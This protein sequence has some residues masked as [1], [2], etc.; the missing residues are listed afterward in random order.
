MKLRDKIIVG[1][2]IL[3]LILV[4]RYLFQAKEGFFDIISDYTALK[5]RIISELDP[6]FKMS[7]FIREQ[8]KSM[9]SAA[10]GEAGEDSLNERYKAMYSCS[11][12]LASS[13]QTCSMLIGGLGPNTRMKYVSADIYTNL[14]CWSDERTIALALMKIK[15]DLPERIVREYEWLV[16][17]IEKLQ[18]TLS[19]G[20]NPP[21][22]PPSQEEINKIVEDSKKEG[23]KDSCEADAI[24]AKKAKEEAMEENSYTIP[25]VSSEI[26]RINR[27]LDNPV[28]QDTLGKIKNSLE[29]ILKLQSDLDK[30]KNGTLYKWQQPKPKKSYPQF[31]GGDRTASFIFSM[32]QNR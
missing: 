27:L 6:Y 31:Q 32:Q 16:S 12:S 28:L 17:I 15:D 7:R 18:E 19:A 14:P 26:A 5:E 24:K 1:C 2:L 9:T 20:E 22:T 30:L 29:V 10:G 8:L 25:E 21:T 11:D 13:R 3:V 23:F 4:H